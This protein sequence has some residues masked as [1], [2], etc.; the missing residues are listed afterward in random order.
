MIQLVIFLLMT[1]ISLALPLWES[2][3]PSP[4]QGLYLI[5]T[6]CRTDSFMGP[7]YSLSTGRKGSKITG[8][9]EE[10]SLG[11]YR[12]SLEMTKEGNPRPKQITLL[13]NKTPMRKFLFQ[14]NRNSI[15][16]IRLISVKVNDST[17]H[18]L[19]TLERPFIRP[20]DG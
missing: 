8:T 19:Y 11:I 5:I 12:L 14:Y 1:K 17:N 16:Q 9:E 3:P 13:Y 7:G 18:P 4:K 15:G 10:I 2:S 20:F 6:P